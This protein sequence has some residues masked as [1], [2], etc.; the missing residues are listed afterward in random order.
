VLAD[1][2]T[3]AMGLSFRMAGKTPTR[4]IGPYPLPTH[5]STPTRRPEKIPQKIIFLPS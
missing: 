3:F 2:E 5:T 1:K 4:L